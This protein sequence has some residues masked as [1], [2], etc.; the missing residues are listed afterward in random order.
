M[1]KIKSRHK[2]RF[3]RQK[4]FIF[5]LCVVIFGLFMKS[6]F[7]NASTQGEFLGVSRSLCKFI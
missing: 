6:R 3:R 7:S 2:K 1:A 4:Q 5:L